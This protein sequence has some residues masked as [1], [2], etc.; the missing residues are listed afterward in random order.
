MI[1]RRLILAFAVL[2]AACASVQPSFPAAAAAGA[3]QVIIFG[4]TPY[5]QMGH[6]DRVAEQA[7]Y[8]H[9]L[10]TIAA[11][12]AA[13]VVHIGDFTGTVC[14][15]S[16]FA[17]RVREFDAIPHPLVYT[18]GDNEWADCARDG[19]EPLERLSRL[20]ALFAAGDASMG[21]R[22][23]PLARQSADPRFAR[24]RENARWSLGGV[25]FVTLHVV[26]AN[27]NRGRE[28]APGAE[29]VERTAA[30]LAWLRDSFAHARER[31]M[32]GVV[33]FTQADLQLLPGE[34]RNPPALDGFAE[35]RD[36]LQR[37]AAAFPRPVALVHG[38]SHYYRVDKPFNVPGTDR[39]LT[40]FTRAETFGDPDVHA[41]LMTVDPADPALFRFAPF[42]VRENVPD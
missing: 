24:Y 22:T 21:A 30:N 36:E 18:P 19:F 16:L 7:A 28:A 39:V 6:P 25:L 1:R 13:F 11:H 2:L 14:S 29:Y 5:R 31:G 38:D 35:V 4:D 17:E 33:V 10:D 37:Q 42:I 20:R 15:D 9:L 41:L 3:F 32:L 8:H 26:G 40:T 34:R 23:L 12:P 27:N